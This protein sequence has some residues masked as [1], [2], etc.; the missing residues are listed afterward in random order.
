MTNP[1]LPS[2]MLNYTFEDRIALQ[3]AFMPFLRYGGLF[4]ETT[5]E[6]EMGSPVVI[7]LTLPDKT[8]HAV[9]GTVAWINPFLG[10]RPKGVGIA[11]EEEVKTQEVKSKIELALVG[12]P[13][14]EKDFSTL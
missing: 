3:K 8:R 12:L 13:P 1:K 14:L 10:H 5:K 7:L 6:L 9:S 2:G 4:I 11:F